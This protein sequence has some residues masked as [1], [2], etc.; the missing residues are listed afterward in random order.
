MDSIIS[1]IEG[2]ATKYTSVNIGF[3]I[4]IAILIVAI[5]ACLFILNLSYRK[6]KS[7]REKIETL[8]KE[9]EALKR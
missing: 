7:Q 1:I 6:M 5:I 4:V 2:W 9:Y 8:K 3:G